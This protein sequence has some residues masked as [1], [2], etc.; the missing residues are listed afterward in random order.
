MQPKRN[1]YTITAPEA[2][3]I[4]RVAQWVM[5]DM[6]AWVEAGDAERYSIELMRNPTEATCKAFADYVLPL[7]KRGRITL[8]LHRPEVARMKAFIAAILRAV[9]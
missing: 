3:Y 7:G 2:S 4:L 8:V 6:G 1:E 5:Y 9:R